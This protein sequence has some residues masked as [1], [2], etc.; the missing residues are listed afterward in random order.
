MELKM[1]D[2]RTEIAWE[3]L[4]L[5]IVLPSLLPPPSLLLLCIIQFNNHMNFHVAKRY[6]L[7]YTRHA[8]QQH[9]QCILFCADL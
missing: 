3:K 4:E 5:K 7:Q 8:Q 1:N 2:E 9:T 6:A